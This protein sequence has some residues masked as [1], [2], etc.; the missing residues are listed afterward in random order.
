VAVSGAT[1]YLG[2]FP[3][4]HMIEYKVAIGIE[5]AEAIS[6]ENVSTGVTIAEMVAESIGSVALL[7]DNPFR[8][9]DIKS[10]NFDIRILPKN[11][12]SH[13]WSVDLSDSRVKAG[14]QIKIE[15]VVESYLSEKKKHEFSLKIP[16]E[17][18]PGKYELIVC[19]SSEYEQHLRKA[20]PYRFMAQDLT[21]LIKALNDALSIERDKLYCLLVLPPSGVAVERAELPDLPATKA[22]VLQN[23]TRALRTQPYPQWI[24]KSLKTGTVVSDKKTMRIT[25]EK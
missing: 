16:D 15:A 11:I 4:D 25:V 22:L 9:I 6:F 12:I 24:E 13:I 17:L 10:L 14:Q 20:V 21:S 23:A 3:P 8:E 5:N 19:G 7:M 1:F 18:P 2:S